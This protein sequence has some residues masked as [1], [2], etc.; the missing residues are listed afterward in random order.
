M[1]TCLFRILKIALYPLIYCHRIIMEAPVIGFDN[2][3]IGSGEFEH[4]VPVDKPHASR[5]T[6]RSGRVTPAISKAGL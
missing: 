6:D 4:F 5:H 2:E 1:K 3:L